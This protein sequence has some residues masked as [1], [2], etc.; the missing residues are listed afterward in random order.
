M[1]SGQIFNVL[2]LEMSEDLI[3]LIYSIVPPLL[4][5]SIYI[6]HLGGFSVAESDKEQIIYL[7]AFS[8]IAAGQIIN[9]IGNYIPYSSLTRFTAWNNVISSLLVIYLIYRSV[10]SIKINN[11]DLIFSEP[12]KQRNILLVITY[13]Y[14]ILTYFKALSKHIALSNVLILFII[15]FLV[16]SRLEKLEEESEEA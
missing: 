5:S 13:V 4:I 6:E 1:L 9:F 16:F 8:L 3:I 14:V 11:G 2:T 10:K 12:E 7:Y 15:D